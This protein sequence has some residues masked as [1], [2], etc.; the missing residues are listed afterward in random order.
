MWNVTG[1]LAD[2]TPEREYQKAKTYYRYKFV[3]SR[4]LLGFGGRNTHPPL[5]LSVAK[6]ASLVDARHAASCDCGCDHIGCYVDDGFIN[7]QPLP[8]G[9]GEV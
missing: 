8:S 2:V 1:R 6:V 7:K 5:V 4:E 9:R 3:R